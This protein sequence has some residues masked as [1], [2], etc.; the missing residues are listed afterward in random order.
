MECVPA[1]A[2]TQISRTMT[3]EVCEFL[4]RVVGEI[5]R[6][7]FFYSS[8]E[9]HP[10]PRPVYRARFGTI[11]VM[12]RKLNSVR[13][14][15]FTLI[16]LLV[17]IAIIAVLA[18]VVILTLNPAELLRQSRDSSRLSDTATLKSAISV[19]LVDVTSP[20][21]ASSSAGYADAY[22]SQVNPPNVSA[23]SGIATIA[24]ANVTGSVS[25]KNDST[26]W[27]PVNF[28]AISAGSPIGSLPVDPT[29]STTS[30]ASYGGGPLI[31]GYV[32]TS[33]GFT[34]KLTAHMES[35]KYAGGSADVEVDGGI[36]TSTYETGSNPN[37]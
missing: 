29:N 19:Y 23:T 13:K 5:Q 24:T 33:T 9:H 6:P 27:I 10:R 37:L 22:F 8:F 1:V 2:T 36:S 3:A 11:K 35:N 21:I 7:L 12:N 17:V 32:A 18:V 20:N 14:R 31:Y 34:F 15:G 16:E 26:G 25:R 28:K 4:D 30:V